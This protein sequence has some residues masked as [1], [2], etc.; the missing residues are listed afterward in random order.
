MLSSIA[1]LFIHWVGDYLLQTNEIAAKKS[2][3][4][5]WLTLH[6]LL[7]TIALLIGVFILT[8]VGVISLTNILLFVGVNGALHWIT[9]LITSRI[10]HRIA[11]KPRPY[12]LLIGF[13]QFLH[14]AALLSTLQWLAQASTLGN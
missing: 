14:A 8:Y 3:S 6:V 12:Y 9:D 1:I 13:D 4:I 5:R 11:H 2:K 10:G 7:Y